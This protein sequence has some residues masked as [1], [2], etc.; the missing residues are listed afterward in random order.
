MEPETSCSASFP[1]LEKSTGIPIPYPPCV[2]AYLL[3]HSFFKK[4]RR[5]KSETGRC[6]CNKMYHFNVGARFVCLTFYQELLVLKETRT[7]IHFRLSIL[8]LLFFGLARLQ[9][10]RDL[11]ELNDV[12]DE[13]L[14]KSSGDLRVGNVNHVLIDVEID[15]G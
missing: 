7:E 11:V 9:L 1:L 5:C 8:A 6:I 13:V 3:L 4:E 15:I 2:E 10:A 12:A 14:S